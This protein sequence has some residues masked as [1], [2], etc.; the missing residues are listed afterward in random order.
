MN[1]HAY[2]G[3]TT[4]A[5]KKFLMILGVKVKDTDYI[6]D[7]VCSYYNLL[8][9]QLSGLDRQ[10]TFCD[11]RHVY[12]YLATMYTNEGLRRIGE[13]INRDHASTIHGRNKIAKLISINDPISND[14]NKLHELI[15][16]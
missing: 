16:N 13:K 2:A 15:K 9:H 1:Y 12:C 6:M 5:Q 7:V 4:F 14:I 10:R 3:L 11:A 8:P